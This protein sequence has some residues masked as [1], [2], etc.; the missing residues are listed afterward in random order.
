MIDED[1]SKE[2]RLALNEEQISSDI[3]NAGYKIREVNSYFLSYNGIV[4]NSVRNKALKAKRMLNILFHEIVE[5]AK[6]DEYRT[7]TDSIDKQARDAVCEVVRYGSLAD[8]AILFKK[9][10]EIILMS[11][12]VEFAFVDMQNKLKSET[13]SAN[14]VAEG[15]N[16]NII[17]EPHKEF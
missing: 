10:E 7:Y 8:N 1:I 9:S 5:L 11:K 3:K 13:N 16:E 17:L 12:E 14:T 4:D 15:T 6:D 2:N